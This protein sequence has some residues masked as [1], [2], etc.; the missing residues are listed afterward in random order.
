MKR[1]FSGLAMIFAGLFSTHVF[2]DCPEGVRKETPQEAAFYQKVQGQLGEILPEA[3]ANWTMTRNPSPPLGWLCK[4]TPEGSFAVKVTA[5]YTYRPPKAEADRMMAEGRKVQA[6]I[7]ALE[8]LPPEVAKERQ[9]WIGK[10]SE[11]IRAARQADQ[12]GNKALAKEKYAERDGYSRKANEVRTKH[13]ASVKPQVDA[14]RAKLATLNYA[15]QGVSV[16]VSVN[17]TYPEKLDPAYVSE[18]AVGKVPD[19]RSPGL[20]VQSVRVILKGP[21]AKR[22]ELRSAVQKAKMERLLE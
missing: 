13:L 11:A 4:G 5:K 9:V 2:A 10:T 19:P 20:K 7:N 3:P 17:E 22:E 12:E 1:V 15:P 16:E 6:E 18:V 8:T 21:T 14:L